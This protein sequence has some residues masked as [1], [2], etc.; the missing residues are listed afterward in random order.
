MKIK[1]S[2]PGHKTNAFKKVIIIIY[3][4]K[5]CLIFFFG[6]NEYLHLTT[7]SDL[8]NFDRNIFCK[9]SIRCI[10]RSSEGK[11]VLNDLEGWV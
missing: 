9:L 7:L 10:I 8:L 6:I 2:K 11:E 1:S 4:Y 3:T 5:Q